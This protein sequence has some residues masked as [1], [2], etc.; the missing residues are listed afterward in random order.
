MV[1]PRGHPTA[2]QPDATSQGKQPRHKAANHPHKAI[3][4]PATRQPT[5]ITSRPKPPPQGSRHGS[6]PGCRSIRG[7]EGWFSVFMLSNFERLQQVQSPAASPSALCGHRRRRSPKSDDRLTCQQT[8]LCRA[9]SPPAPQPTLSSLRR[10]HRLRSGPAHVTRCDLSSLPRGHW[11]A[12]PPK[13]YRPKCPPRRP[14][15][16]CL[17]AP[18]LP[19][20]PR[21]VARQRPARRR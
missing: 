12:S 10:G 1:P 17:P 13:S 9:I 6:A 21:E 20:H 4:A 15:R 2:P 7:H 14:V 19:R 3:P 5:T 16:R 18:R 8:C 11:A